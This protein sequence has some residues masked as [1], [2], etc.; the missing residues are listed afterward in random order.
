MRVRREDDARGK[1]DLELEDYL[2]FELPIDL[3]RVTR[4][5]RA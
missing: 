5:A 4:A 1:D 3:T 2:G